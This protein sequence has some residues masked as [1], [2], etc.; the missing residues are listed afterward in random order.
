MKECTLFGYGFVVF[1]LEVKEER[2]ETWGSTRSFQG[3]A[4]GEW[5]SAEAF[6]VGGGASWGAAHHNFRSSQ[7]TKATVTSLLTWA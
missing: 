5:A 2:W 3:S 4:A 6:F 7:K 1:V